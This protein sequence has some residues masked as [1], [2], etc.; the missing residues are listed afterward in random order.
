[1]PSHTGNRGSRTNSR[2]APN[3]ST[4]S[5]V[6]GAKDSSSGVSHFNLKKNTNSQN[7]SEPLY[8]EVSFKG[9]LM[10]EEN[11]SII[12][13]QQNLIDVDM[14][15]TLSTVEEKSTCRQKHNH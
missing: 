4:H 15:V 9:D 13:N 8:T 12:Y 1:V 2:Q 10:R 11:S 14:P 6:S 7:T 5:K 3:V